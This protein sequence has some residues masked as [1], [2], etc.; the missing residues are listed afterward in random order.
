[1]D[2]TRKEDRLP[3]ARRMEELRLGHRHTQQECADALGVGQSTYAQME[4]GDIRFRRRDLV[5]LS[6]L[7]GM[8]PEEAFPDFFAERSAA[9][10]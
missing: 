8:D 1:M 10:A 7:Y 2:L 5:T 9:A 6:V 4:S 3:L